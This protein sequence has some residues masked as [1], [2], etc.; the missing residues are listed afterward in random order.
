MKKQPIPYKSVLQERTAMFLQFPTLF[1]IFL[2]SA[3]P[4]LA[5]AQVITVNGA[6]PP[7][8]IGL[9]LIHEHIMVDW[10]GAD[11]TGYHRWN[12]DTIVERALP[13]L[14]A[15]KEH[16]VT[17]FLDCT[18]A[19]LGRDPYILKRLSDSTGI[20]ILT[21]TG[22]YGSGNNKY[23]PKS[24]RNNSPKEMAAHWIDEFQHGIDGSGIRPGFI[25][26]AV[27][28]KEK[29]SEIHTNL[30]KAAAL[31]HLETGMTIV[32]H[33][34]EDAPAMAQ[35]KVLKEMGVSPKAFV[36]T[37][38]QNGSVAGYL[39][40]A[41][42][43]AWVSLDNIHDRPTTNANDPGSIG[44]Y[45]KTLSELK[46]YGILNHI[47]ISHD[48][49]WYNVGQK[50]GGDYRGYT[51]LFAKLIPRLKENGFTKKDIDLLLRENPKSAYAIKIRRFL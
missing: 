48:A 22:Y 44:W 7:E 26:M 3:F 40:A 19:Y 24:I 35:I 20:N 43:G 5:R 49:G 36:W 37:H 16:G 51:D 38:A 21:N 32:S 29:L 10:I 33:T 23:I 11:S 47:L 14:K 34:G 27:E 46:A 2:I 12:K 45:V 1:L 18:P 6:I 42:Q 25:K 17:S 28:N 8:E 13:Y 9:V 30:I 41:G 4:S 15:L 31:T 50:N 39:E